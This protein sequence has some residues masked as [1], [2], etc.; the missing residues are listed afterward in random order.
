MYLPEI[1]FLAERGEL[2]RDIP[3]G[4]STAGSSAG[5]LTSSRVIIGGA[6][7]LALIGVSFAGVYLWTFGRIRTLQT[8]QTE[9]TE[10]LG[11]AQAELARLQQLQAE[12]GDIQTRTQALKAFFDRVQ[13]WS[14]I[15]EEIRNRIPPDTWIDTV[16]TSD[17]DVTIEGQS[18]TF[19]QVNDFQLALLQSP[20]VADV[21]INL[22]EFNEGQETQDLIT[23]PA[24]DYTLTV[25]LENKA[26]SEYLPTLAARGSQGL[27]RKIEILRGLE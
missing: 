7:V 21:V 3:A 22:A 20:L 12:L 10:E 5:G 8:E 19:D 15:L 2:D 17:T 18:A 14:A 1:N 23:E 26:V 4:E 11:E 25:T 9:V 13:P 27:V 6:A 24:I 16:S